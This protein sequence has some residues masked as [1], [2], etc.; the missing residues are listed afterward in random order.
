[1]IN[2][3]QNIKEKTVKDEEQ[4]PHLEKNF[5]LNKNVKK[6]ITL[7]YLGS[8]ITLIVLFSNRIYDK[9]QMGE[10]AFN[11]I[12]VSMILFFLSVISFIFYARLIT[13]FRETKTGLRLSFT[14]IIVL[15]LLYIFSVFTGSYILISFGLL[16]LLIKSYQ[17]QKYCKKHNIGPNVNGYFNRIT[18]TYVLLTALIALLGV[19]LD[20]GNLQLPVIDESIDA[21]VNQLHQKIEQSNI[22]G[23][24]ET[25]LSLLNEISDYINKM[26]MYLSAAYSFLYI[27]TLVALIYFSYKFIVVSN[28]HIDKIKKELDT[29][30]KKNKDIDMDVYKDNKWYDAL[31]TLIQGTMI[32]NRPFMSFIASFVVLSVYS[33]TAVSITFEQSLFIVISTFFA[34]GFGFAFN[35]LIDYK[36]D[37]VGHTER[38][39]PKGYLTIKF[40][41]ILCLLLVFISIVASTFVNSTYTMLMIISN[42]LLFTYSLVNNKFGILSNLIAALLAALLFVLGMAA[43]AISLEFCLFAFL[44]F[45]FILAREI[46]LDVRDYDSDVKINKSSFPIIFCIN[47]AHLFST[48]F[49]IFSSLL[50]VIVYLYYDKFI[51]LMLIIVASNVLNWSFYIYYLLNQNEESRQKFIVASRFTMLILPISIII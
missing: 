20:Y 2:D 4:Y 24:S 14:L 21:I 12:I 26:K 47:K 10:Y 23:G 32:I 22:T 39:I 7:L 49:F 19:F 18:L 46:I 45:F 29:F 15:P 48:L 5:E 34:S 40:V 3:N 11:V 1:M 28:V 41:R 44:A 27:S 43:G 37:F 17:M 51:Y 13:Y 33:S 38:V 9:I 31:A 42:I 6:L 35:D 30:Y 36:K 25:A 50:G 16:F 8:V